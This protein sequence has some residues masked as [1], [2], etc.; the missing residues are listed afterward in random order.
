MK[1]KIATL[2]LSVLLIGCDNSEEL[3]FHETEVVSAVRSRDK[4][5]TQLLMGSPEKPY[6]G[7]PTIMIRT[8]ELGE[9][10]ITGTLEGRLSEICENGEKHDQSGKSMPGVHPGRGPRHGGVWGP[11]TWRNEILSEGGASIILVVKDEK[12]L[13]VAIYRG[14]LDEYPTIEIKTEDSEW[15]ELPLG[16]ENL[17]NLFGPPKASHEWMAE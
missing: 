15:H 5:F 6:A 11:G 10:Q 9:F 2:L 8:K 1:S 3:V 13:G 16:R 12:V 14:I 7:I 4:V 17:L